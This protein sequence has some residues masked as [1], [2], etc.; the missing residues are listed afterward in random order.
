[1]RSEHSKCFL[2][3]LF[4]STLIHISSN[5]HFYTPNAFKE[6]IFVG[7]VCMGFPVFSHISYNVTSQLT[8]FSPMS[9]FRTPWKCQK[10]RVIFYHDSY[11]VSLLAL[12]NKVKLLTIQFFYTFES[13]A[14]IAIQYIFILHSQKTCHYI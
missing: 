14:I 7:L 8:H 6:F 13:I 3:C 9:H 10:T 11:T 12:W 4:R 2:F 5:L 1:M